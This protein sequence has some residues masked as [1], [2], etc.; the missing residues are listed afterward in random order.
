MR[1]ESLPNGQNEC[2]VSIYAVDD[3]I[4]IGQMIEAVLSAE[5]YTLKV[6]DDPF[7]L[8]EAFRQANPKPKIILTDYFMGKM[9]GLELLTR[10]KQ[11]DPAVKTILLSGTVE[12][13][14]VQE[15]AS[16]PDKFVQ[17]PFRPQ[18][19]VATVRGLMP[20]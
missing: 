2:S 13:D 20:V 10:C 5:G 16:Q 14:F 1:E 12:E 7:S 3:E 8:L 17:K 15:H 4:I 11:L 9:N 18:N 6:F 19:L